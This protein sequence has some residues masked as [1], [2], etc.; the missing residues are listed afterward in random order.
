[1]LGF[2]RYI[3]KFGDILSAVLELTPVHG[4]FQRVIVSSLE[5]RHLFGQNLSQ[6][7]LQ[8]LDYNKKQLSIQKTCIILSQ[9]VNYDWAIRKPRQNLRKSLKNLEMRRLY[10]IYQLHKWKK[11]TKDLEK[12][13][14]DSQ[15]CALKKIYFCREFTSLILTTF[16]KIFQVKVLENFSRPM[17]FSHGTSHKHIIQIW[18]IFLGKFFWKTSWYIKHTVCFINYQQVNLVDKLINKEQK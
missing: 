1:M 4:W 12:D 17:R 5:W 14:K 8:A 6:I 10:E 3:R 7:V 2:F 11:S 18:F 9:K 16:S 15:T 13:V